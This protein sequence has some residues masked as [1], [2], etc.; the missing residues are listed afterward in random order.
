MLG[1]EPD[2]I[3]HLSSMVIMLSVSIGRLLVI[4]L[5]M[6]KIAVAPPSH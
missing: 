4:V 5:A 1:A 2:D 3:S 6:L